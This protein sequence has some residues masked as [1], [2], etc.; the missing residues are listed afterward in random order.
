MWATGQV[1]VPEPL[2][3]DPSGEVLG[4]PFMMTRAVDGVT[5]T[6]SIFGYA[7]SARQRLAEDAFANL[8]RISAVDV[9]GLRGPEAVQGLDA[10]RPAW[11]R[12]LD[13]WEAIHDESSLGPLPMVRSAI[14]ALRANPPEEPEKVSVVHGD[15]RFGNYLYTPDGVRG[16]LDWEMAHLGDAHEDLAWTMKTNWRWADKEKIWGFVEDD[17]AVVTAWERTSGLKLNRRSL[18]WWT[19]LNHVKGAGLWLKAGN[20]VT[21]QTTDRVSYVLTHWRQIPGEEARIA[22]DIEGVWR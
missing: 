6:S 7:P 8:G 20:A 21:A 19:V 22:R 9:S 14:R 5:D 15:F 1:L 11:C 13:Y 12:E 16:I 4:S 10:G 3:A 18:D 17:D 2:V